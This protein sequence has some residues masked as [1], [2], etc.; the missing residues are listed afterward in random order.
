MKHRLKSSY[1]GWSKGLGQKLNNKEFILIAETY[2][3]KFSGNFT[4][5]D[6]HLCLFFDVPLNNKFMVNYLNC[7]TFKLKILLL[8]LVNFLSC[9]NSL[10][11]IHLEVS[12]MR[13]ASLI[14]SLPE[15]ATSRYERKC[16]I[17]PISDAE[18]LTAL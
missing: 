10:M 11:F 6:L 8:I 1:L 14:Q 4:I 18:I 9:G 15:M 2:I 7:Q 5:S 17:G 13:A 12:F 16:Q 3:L